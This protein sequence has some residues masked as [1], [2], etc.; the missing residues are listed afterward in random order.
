MS[1]YI[2][3]ELH[4]LY[5]DYYA[6]RL[7]LA[8]YRYQRGLLLD[9]LSAGGL[10][11]DDMATKPRASLPELQPIK[12]DVTPVKETPP[13]SF[14]WMYV[15]AACIPLLALVVYFVTRQI[16]E[17]LSLPPVADSSASVDEV[18][19]VTPEEEQAT[20]A[21]EVLIPDV[22]QRL[23]EEFVSRDDWRE[24]SLRE[25]QASWGRLPARDRIVAKGA[26][27]FAPLVDGLE[28]QIVEAAEFSTDP[29]NDA[30]LAGLYQFSLQLG[31]PELAPS[32][33]RPPKNAPPRQQTI[34]PV[35]PTPVVDT[36]PRPA[37]VEDK[38][39][40][41]DED[42][43]EP[44]EKLSLVETEHTCRASQLESRRRSCHDLL[45]NGSDGPAM[46]VLPARNDDDGNEVAAPFAIS[47]SEISRREFIEYCEQAG[48]S[49]PDDPWPGEDMPVV[50]V[51]WNEAV[52]YCA[53]LSERTGYLYRLPDAGEW[54]Y[55]ARGGSVSEYPFG[56]EI[57]P[58]MA[59]YSGLA[60]YDRPLPLGD[61]TTRRNKFGLWHVVGNVRE[62]V[63]PDGVIDG[64]VRTA[65]G[66]SFADSED[67]LRLSNRQKLATTDRDAQ[68]GFRI[69]REL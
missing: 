12:E 67:A 31:L 17:P 11:A 48:V 43:P 9:S 54:E 44:A 35:Q 26:L 24:P 63:A 40:T 69:L 66:G 16:D 6:D 51:S 58:A 64:E 18:I 39:P 15:G 41:I 28:Y 45:D 29:E 42:S 53:W 10:D 32:G 22:G 2:A 34:D 30:R 33:W 23:A 61:T 50:N 21:E 36:R 57:S 7:A 55:S 1:D 56:E 5:R 37:A 62:W 38:P 65:R 25:F 52:A 60:D 27:W 49:C 59:R 19:E 4:R 68:T 14:R 20:V 46:R 8:D 13:K 47:V 3:G